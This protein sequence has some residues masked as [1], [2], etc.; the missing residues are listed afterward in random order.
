[1]PANR[2]RAAAAAPDAAAA[3][4][5]KSSAADAAAEAKEKASVLGELNAWRESRR[6]LRAKGDAWPED[7]PAA[8]RSE[9]T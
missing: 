1:M 3:D 9:A 4:A 7:E 8:L 2:R 6:K 5:A